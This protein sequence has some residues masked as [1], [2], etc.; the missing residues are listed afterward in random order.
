MQACTQH[1]ILGVHKGIQRL[2]TH[3]EREWFGARVGSKG[4]FPNLMLPTSC[5]YKYIGIHAM[6]N[7][8]STQGNLKIEDMQ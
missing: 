1:L 8:R 4:L 7:P 3:D 5:I 2:K 6:F